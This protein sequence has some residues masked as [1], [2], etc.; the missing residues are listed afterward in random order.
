[1]RSSRNVSGVIAS[2][3]KQSRLWDCGGR[4]VW[5]AS[6][7]LAMTAESGAIQK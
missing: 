5:I 1:M 3:A 6:L 4:L 2:K 7:S